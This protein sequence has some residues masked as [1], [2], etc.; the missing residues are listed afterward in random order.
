MRDNGS[1]LDRR[2][3]LGTASATAALA[4]SVAAVRAADGPNGH[5][6]RDGRPPMTD[7]RAT[8]GDTRHGPKWDELFTLTVGNDKGDL[9]GR[10]QRV[11]QAAVDTVARMGGGTVRLLPRDIS[12]TERRLSV[13]KPA[14][15]W[16]W[17]GHGPDQGIIGHV[18]T[19]R[20]FGLV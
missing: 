5:S 13:P 20:R 9:F 1:A 14:T 17:V 3:F 11:I 15:D 8:S 10:D 12:A 4:G 7:P 19:G 2:H 6:D 16:E 18:K